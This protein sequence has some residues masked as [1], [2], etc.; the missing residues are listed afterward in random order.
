MHTHDLVIV[1]GGPGGLTAGL[2]AARARMDAVLLERL[3]PGG[4]VLTTDIVENWPGDVEGVSGFDLSDRMR[5][6]ALKFGLVIESKEITKLTVDGDCKVLSTPDGEIRGKA[7]VIAVGAQP[8]KLGVPGEELLIGKG[9]SYCGTCDGPF[10]RDQVVVC[11]GGGDTA[12]EEAVFLTRFAS[13]VYLVHRRDELRAAGVLAERV[14][15]NE[16]IEVLWSQVPL[17]IKGENKVEAV[18]LKKLSD[19]EEYDLPC[20]GAFVFVGTTPNTEFLRGVLDMDRQGFIICDRDQ[21]T[22]LNG[23]FAAGDCCSK[24]LRQI[25]VAAGEGALATYAAQR[26]LEEV[27]D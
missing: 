22:S 16:K 14:L 21:H 2:Y 5:D 8:R 9:V 3:S 26:Y 12:A 18:R 13:K 15:N 20:D 24:L 25:V 17:E 23:V 1:G 4:Q 7:V 19:G 11:F 27:H 10:Y 6:H